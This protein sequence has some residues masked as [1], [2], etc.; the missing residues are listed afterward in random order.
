MKII[1]AHLHLFPA[2]EWADETARKVGHE[3]TLEHLRSEYE[4][5]NIIHGVVMGN[6]SVPAKAAA[7][8][9]TDTNDNGG[10]AKAVQKYALQEE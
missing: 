5:L 3:N 4:R 10:F 1:D 8:Y 2:G 9:I 6:G 7:R